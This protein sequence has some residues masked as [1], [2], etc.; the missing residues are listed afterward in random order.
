MNFVKNFWRT[1]LA[2]FCLETFTT[3]TIS[4]D[5]HL[6]KIKL[7]LPSEKSNVWDLDNLVKKYLKIDKYFNKMNIVLAYQ[8]IHI[9]VIL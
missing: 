3:M 2:N 1:H 9:I 7:D 6:K 5:K 4:T 8:N